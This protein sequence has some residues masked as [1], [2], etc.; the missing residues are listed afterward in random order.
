[1][2][3]CWHLTFLSVAA[4][5]MDDKDK[6]KWKR[7]LP[8]HMYDYNYKFGENYYGSQ[9]DYIGTRDL[10][11][12]KLEPPEAA[13]Y[14]ERFASRPFYGN[15]RGLPY[16]DRESALSQPLLSRRSASA[17]RASKDREP[18]DIPARSRTGRSGDRKL[19]FNYDDVGAEPRRRLSLFDDTDF[20]TPIKRFFDSDF[21]RDQRADD[22]IRIKPA[23]KKSIRDDIT[24]LEKEF[25]KADAVQRGTG[26]GGRRWEEVVYNDALDTPGKKTVKRDEVSYSI[27]G[28]GATVRKSSYQESSKFESSKPPR[29]PPK[30][31]RL[32]SLEND[33]DFKL[34]VRPR[35]RHLSLSDDDDFKFTSRSIKSRF[36]DDDDNLDYP[37]ISDHRR[38]KESAQLTE[39]VNKMISKMRKHSIGDGDG[40]KYTRTVRSSSLDPYDGIS[41]LTTST[42]T[43]SNQYAYGVP[44]R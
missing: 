14:A 18:D 10:R 4:A 9:K 22:D 8:Y 7:R 17:S 31:S 41:R 26:S 42:Q 25:R 43:R 23:T 24:K 12:S 6:K 32:L 34:P 20:K 5:S 37:R 39:N 1:M 16:E 19:S 3:T 11:P 35:R 21:G 29:A 38:A 28:T 27:P 2:S 30:P 40:Y 36:D 13:T 15:T 44:K 33:P